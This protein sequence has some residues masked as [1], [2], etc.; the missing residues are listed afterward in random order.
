MG[1][2]EKEIWKIAPGY[3]SV[4]CGSLGEIRD[5]ETKTIL[6][7][8]ISKR[9]G[10]YFVNIIPDNESKV[11]MVRVHILIALAFL[12]PN[13]NGYDV[14][15]KDGNKLNNRVNNLEYCTRSENVRRAYKTGINPYVNPIEIVETGEKYNSID[16]CARAINGDPER[17]RQCLLYPK[18][19]RKSHRGY[20]FKSLR[21]DEPIRKP[22]KVKIVETGEIF[23]SIRDCERAINGF[24]SNIM[25]A[26]KKQYSIQRFTF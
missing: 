21:T 2:I 20:H 18:Y 5:M 11:H 3:S 8:Y 9:P 15:H 19:R 14:E 10:Y 17:I 22:L 7:K 1:E 24:H 23:D 25:F 16:E 12:G 13:P 4:E 26:C 6:D